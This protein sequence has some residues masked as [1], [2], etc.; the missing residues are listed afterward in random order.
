MVVMDTAL[1]CLAFGVVWIALFVLDIDAV[2]QTERS[3]NGVA[4]VYAE[5]S[6]YNCSGIYYPNTEEDACL[7]TQ[8]QTQ[9]AA[10]LDFRVDYV[11]F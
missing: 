9:S 11:V 2:I 3:L 7:Q 1:G 5:Y 10:P 6:K 8:T 4:S